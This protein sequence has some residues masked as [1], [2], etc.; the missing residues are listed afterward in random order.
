LTGADDDPDADCAEGSPGPV[1]GA[2]TGDALAAT[3]TTTALS[4]TIVAHASATV[5]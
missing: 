2:A 5:R 1:D 4:T 3:P